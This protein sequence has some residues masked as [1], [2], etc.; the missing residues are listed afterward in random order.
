MPN[1][2]QAIFEYLQNNDLPCGQCGYNLRG[3]PDVRCSECGWVIVL[4]EDREQVP[5]RRL[6][7]MKCRQDLSSYRGEACPTCG[8]SAWIKPTHQTRAGRMFG[9][10]K[11]HLRFLMTAAWISVIVPAAAGFSFLR[12]SSLASAGFA[13]SARPVRPDAVVVVAVAALVPGLLFFL[14][15]GGATWIAERNPEMQ[16]S[17]RAITGIITVTAIVCGVLLAMTL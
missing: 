8:A 6:W 9:N 12:H 17:L 4:P 14:W 2:A 3:A 10:E 1:A 16:A 11:G 5:S 7:C 13:A 15:K